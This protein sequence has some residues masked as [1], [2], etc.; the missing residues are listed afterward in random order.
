MILASLF[1]RICN[2]WDVAITSVCVR[3][4]WAQAGVSFGGKSSFYGWPVLKMAQGSSISIGKNFVARSRPSSNSVGTIQPVVIST[5]SPSASIQI[6]ND[7]G[8]SGCTIFA[9]SSI[10]LHDRVGLGSGCMIMDNDAHPLDPVE[11]H[12]QT[13]NIRSSPIVIE[14][15]TWIGGRAIILKGTRM[16]A[17]TI[18]QAGS[19]VSGSFPPDCIV[20]GNPA[21]VLRAKK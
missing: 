4:F 9:R 20:G 3:A 13:S 18:V 5:A 10:I 2:G 12:R 1:H 16:G 7:I 8:M 14:S 21:Q 11:R 17:R 6:G 15:D 19:V